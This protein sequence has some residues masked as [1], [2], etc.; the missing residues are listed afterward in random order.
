MPNVRREFSADAFPCPERHCGRRFKTSGGFKKNR[1]LKHQVD[2]PR[3]PA[4]SAAVPPVEDPHPDDDTY[5]PPQSPG[6]DPPPSPPPVQ[7]IPLNRRS[8]GIEYHSLLDGTTCD[9]EGYD[10]PPDALPPP[11]EERAVDDFSPFNSRAEFEFADF[12]YREEEIAGS[13]VD[14]LSQLLAALYR[15][16]DP[17]FADHKDLYA[18]IDAI[19]Q[20]DIP[21]QSFSVTYNEKAAG[22]VRKRGRFE[23]PVP[24]Y[25]RSGVYGWG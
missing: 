4:A 2:R 14:R 21:W 3:I 18:T 23:E 6:P 5:S 9:R 19:Q 16:T 20:G 1:Q 7:T 25:G 10:L 17:P 12:L 22:C 11:W 8:T 24:V 13:R 15:G